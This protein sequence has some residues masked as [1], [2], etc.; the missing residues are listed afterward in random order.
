LA[1]TFAVKLA[2]P[3]PEGLL[4][5]IHATSVLDVHAQSRVVVTVTATSP[6]SAP[7][8]EGFA[9]I[10]VAQRTSDGADTSVTL[11]E[12]QANVPQA[13]V[14]ARSAAHRRGNR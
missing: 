10:D 9:A 5:R 13:T 14:A 3:C 1:S 7:T 2:S 12:P 8:D 11:V 6:P 4:N